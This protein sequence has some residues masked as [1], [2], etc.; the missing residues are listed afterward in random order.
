MGERMNTRDTCEFGSSRR[1]PCGRGLL[2]E[3]LPAWQQKLVMALSKLG[4]YH[5]VLYPANSVRI[6]AY[7]PGQGIHPHMDG[8]VYFPRAAIISLGSQC[9][10]DIYPCSDVDEDQRGFSWDH[11]KEVPKAPELPSDIEPAVSLVL[12]PGSLLIFS[13][14]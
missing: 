9:T 10:F 4:V 14:P 1:C 7:K 13:G 2:Q 12:E 11:D 5:P 6:N 3:A 8:P